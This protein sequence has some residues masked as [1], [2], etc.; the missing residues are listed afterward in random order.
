MNQYDN[1]PP[2]QMFELPPDYDTAV[3]QPS[4]PYQQRESLPAYT[5]N[6]NQLSEPTL[7]VP[8]APFVISGNQLPYFSRRIPAFRN[9]RYVN[10][11]SSGLATI[12]LNV[13]PSSIGNPVP[14]YPTNRIQPA[15]LP[16]TNV[17]EPIDTSGCNHRH[18]TLRAFT[19]IAKVI[20]FF[21][22]FIG[23]VYAI[24]PGI[25]ACKYPYQQS[26]LT[27]RAVYR[28]SFA[29]QEACCITA[30]VLINAV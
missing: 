7:F 17:V 13:N 8:A 19:V 22:V 5:T 2:I 1:L 30:L 24:V 29:N 11:L 3:N 9:V 14:P 12:H 21:L 6:F 23:V 10:Q 26:C 27:W 20:S 18:N 28:A 16:R 15:D 25:L 4:A